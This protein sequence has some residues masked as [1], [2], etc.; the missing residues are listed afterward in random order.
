MV[1]TRFLKADGDLGGENEIKRFKNGSPSHSANGHKLAAEDIKGDV[2]DFWLR[3]EEP[4]G[5][6]GSG[7]SSLEAGC[8]SIMEVLL[9]SIFLTA[10]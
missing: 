5:Y 9:P 1:Y 2:F 10:E 8:Q 7:G 3:R 6:L 4:P